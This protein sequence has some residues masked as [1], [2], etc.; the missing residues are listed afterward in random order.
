[1][2]DVTM[3][4]RRKHGLLNKLEELGDLPKFLWHPW[5][6]DYSVVDIRTFGGGQSSRVK[7]SRLMGTY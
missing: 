7:S 6:L 4:A 3:R 5:V 2:K 1:M